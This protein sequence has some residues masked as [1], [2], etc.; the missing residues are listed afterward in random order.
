M[1]ESMGTECL[2]LKKVCMV[3]L[4]MESSRIKRIEYAIFRFFVVNHPGLR[5]NGLLG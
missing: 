3:F 5:E 1:I 4:F 2:E